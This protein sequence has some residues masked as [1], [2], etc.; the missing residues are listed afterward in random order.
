VVVGVAI[1]AAIGLLWPFADWNWWPVVTGLGVLVLLYVL[2][3]NWLLLGWAP[4]LA[5]LVTVVLLLG[6]TGPWVWGFAAGLALLGYG[7]VRLPDWRLVA[8]GAALTAVFGIGYGVSQYRTDAQQAADAMRV[9]R[10]QQVRMVAGPAELALFR[11]ANGVQAGD[12][13]VACA[14]L[15]PKAGAEF[16]SAAGA[17]DC[18]AAVRALSA[19]VSDKTGY[20]N[21]YTSSGG[22]LRGGLVGPSGAPTAVADGC[23]AS[24][25]GPRLGRLELRR[26]KSDYVVTGYQPCR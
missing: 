14:V 15:G 19:Q 17:A 8:V 1:L 23:A 26:E 25:A 11:L 12:P 6:R 4:H 21:H 18:A 22:L 20:A 5:G 3:L 13:G 16:G 2:R 9:T 24:V 7:L 10:E